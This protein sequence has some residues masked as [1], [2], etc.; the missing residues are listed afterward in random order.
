M[1][2]TVFLLGFSITWGFANNAKAENE[3]GGN[4]TNL[5][6]VVIQSGD[7]LWDIA[8]S[9]CPQTDTRKVVHKI[10][11]LNDLA[12]ANIMPGQIIK[13]PSMD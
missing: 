11:K 4:N 6:E 12:T 2:I 7:T 5:V 8:E 1:I 13:I 9:Y 10:R 3:I